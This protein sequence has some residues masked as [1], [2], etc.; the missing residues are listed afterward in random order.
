MYTGT[1]G[2][3]PVLSLFNLIIIL[4]VPSHVGLL[5]TFSPRSCLFAADDTANAGNDRC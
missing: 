3:L 4:I 2:L 1:H 5:Y